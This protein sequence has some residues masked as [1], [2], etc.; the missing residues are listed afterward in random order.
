MTDHETVNVGCRVGNGVLLRVFDWIDS[1]EAP[2]LKVAR[3]IGIIPL[4]GPVADHGEKSGPA[5]LESVNVVDADLFEKWLD[6]NQQSDLVT[7]GLVYQIKSEPVQQE[8]VAEEHHPEEPEHEEE[9]PE[10]HEKSED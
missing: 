5:P 1:M 9:E 4:S 3:E 7:G 6:Q 2:G 8:P 10:P